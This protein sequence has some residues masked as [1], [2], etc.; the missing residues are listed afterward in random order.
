MTWRDPAICSAR[1][2]GGLFAE[3]ARESLRRIRIRVTEDIMLTPFRTLIPSRARIGFACAL[4]C[5]LCCTP[6]CDKNDQDHSA[7]LVPSIETEPQPAPAADHPAENSNPV[8]R[9]R[10]ARLLPPQTRK[11]PSRSHANL[12]AS[13]SQPQRHAADAAKPDAGSRSQ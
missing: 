5:W 1:R 8:P 7:V 3:R 2:I 6:A 13:P 4:R 12:S 11:S 9:N 10:S